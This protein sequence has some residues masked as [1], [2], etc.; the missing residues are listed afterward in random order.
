MNLTIA[1]PD[2]LLFSASTL[3]SV[4]IISLVKRLN[5]KNYFLVGVLSMYLAIIN[6]ILIILLLFKFKIINHFSIILPIIV[7]LI[8]SLYNILH[9]LSLKYLISKTTKSKIQDLIHLVP[10]VLIEILIFKVY[11]PIINL[12]NHTLVNLFE[13]QHRMYSH[14]LNNY[15][16]SI[17]ILHPIIYVL[18]GAI[19]VYFFYKSPSYARTS[20]SIKSFVYF[21][22]I[23]KI[24][25]M[26]WY[27]IGLIG[28]NIDISYLSEI[29]IIGFS[30]SALII[31]S[32]FLLNPNLIL[33]ITKPIS[34]QK[35]ITHN[36]TKL[37]ST[38]NHLNE[39]IQNNQ[40][41]LNPNYSLTNLSID[42][43]ISTI[44]IRDSIITNGL[45][46]YS[47]YI[48][49]FRIDHAEKLILNGYLETYSIESLCKDSGFQ[50]EVTFYRVFKKIHN[51]TPK[52][53]S[54][55]L[56]NKTT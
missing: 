25:L 30:I 33:E 12:D 53:Y 52:E 54:Y 11:K 15:L 18:L 24:V 21:F 8:L 32:F 35:K 1:F 3:L 2:V 6:I 50:S 42:S 26:S 29:A 19:T 34:N 14:N 28:Y 9:F 41:Y 22:L 10:I 5:A 7:G 49:S 48:N 17:R 39:L 46:N 51:C 20:K 4:T 27:L 44:N 37:N 40:F 23:Q 38:Y 16:V 43:D 31:S 45:K 47:A 56:K 13:T 36:D 55:S